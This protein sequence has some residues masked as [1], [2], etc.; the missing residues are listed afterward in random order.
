MAGVELKNVAKSFGAVTAV[1][2]LD[3]TFEEGSFTTLL[4][5]SGCGKTTILRMVAGLEA[6]T[7]GDILVDRVSVTGYYFKNFGY[8]AQDKPR[9]APMI[10]A[11]RLEWH[12]EETAE[13]PLVPPAVRNTLVVL[14]LVVIL[15][16][17]YR[18]E[19]RDEQKH[20]EL[21]RKMLLENEP[22]TAVIPPT[23][24]NSGTDGPSDS[25]AGSDRDSDTAGTTAQDSP[26]G[27]GDGGA[28]DEKA[29]DRSPVDEDARPADQDRPSGEQT[30]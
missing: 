5:P 21:Q 4:G 25:T 11:A 7:G 28:D 13:A 30:R 16:L 9:F 3:I 24:P 10:L 18:Y 17:L 26:T 29:G 8:T 2:G 27:P 12:P 6:P 14:A 15:V 23:P 1:K 20:A 22:A 19:R